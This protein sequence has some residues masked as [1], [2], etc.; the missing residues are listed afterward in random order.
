MGRYSVSGRSV[1]TSATAN[2]PAAMLWNGSG[3]KDIRVREIQWTKV[4]GTLDRMQIA[5]FST[6]GTP[7][8]TVTPDID[9]DYDRLLGPPSGCTLDLGDF[10]G[11]AAVIQDPALA[12]INLPGVVATGF[13]L[14]FDPPI[15]VP[16]GTGLAVA[17]P[18]AAAVV[19]GDVVFVWDE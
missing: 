17:T 7:G 15:R 4:T 16:A 3:A 13:S 2:E 12:T 10:T 6:R 11:T 14:I 18:T 19:A 1:A 5:R 9:N 8:S